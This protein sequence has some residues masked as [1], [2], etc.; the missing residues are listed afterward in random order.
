MVKVVL[1]GERPKSLNEFWSG[2]HYRQRSKYA[3]GCHELVKIETL[4]QL[5]RNFTIDDYPLFAIF[6]YHRKGRLRS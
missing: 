1:K 4:N 3:K 5:G 6:V 2:M